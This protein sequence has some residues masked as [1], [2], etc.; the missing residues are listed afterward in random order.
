MKD[1]AAPPK[2]EPLELTQWDTKSIPPREWTV[3]DRFPRRNVSLLSGEGGV[4]KS[5]ILLQLAVAHVLGRDW[6]RSVPE[7]GPVIY[8][9][10]EDEPNEIAHRLKAVLDHYGA[11]F[12]DVAGEL[13]IFPMAGTEASL[14]APDY[15]GLLARTPLWGQIYL[16][17]MHVK[18]INI[19][20]DN[21]ADTFVGSENDRVQ[22]RSFITHM[23]RLAIDGNCGV[24]MSSH[25]SLTGIATK[26]GLSGSTQW[27]NGPR[28]RCVLRTPTTKDGDE[29][30]PDVREL[31]FLKSQYGRL[32]ETIL[33]RWKN[34]VF[35]PEP[36][37]GSL[38]QMAAD[39]KVDDLFLKLLARFNEN[40]QSVSPNKGPT[41]APTAFA[42]H[43]DAKGVPSQ[44]FAKAMQR[45]LDAKTVKV[46]T[47]GSPSKQRSRLVVA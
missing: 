24:L 14:V 46:E 19:M 11:T 44:V 30:D 42:N 35:I 5:I 4:G 27:H 26:T 32:G 15:D 8:L 21:V 17:A 9:N 16:A 13:H 34:G 3:H 6:L 40:N 1:D 28:G 10:C 20:I 22:V 37:P 39:K 38:D 41:Y 47:S 25:P 2:V 23:R 33:L 12:A 18:P 36:R 7:Q 31:A 45:L 43:A 29:I